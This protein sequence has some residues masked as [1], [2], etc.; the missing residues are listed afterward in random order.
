VRKQVSQIVVDGGDV[1]FPPLSEFEV[2]TELTVR[3][4]GGQCQWMAGVSDVDTPYCHS[5]SRLALSST[6]I[7]FSSSA[8]GSSVDSEAHQVSQIPAVFPRSK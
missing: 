7:V 8:W 5:A 4:M 3:A 2:D 1:Q 6:P